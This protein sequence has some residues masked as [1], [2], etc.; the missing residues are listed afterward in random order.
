M[1]RFLFTLLFALLFS[2]P[3]IAADITRATLVADS[4]AITP[5]EPLRLGVLL[6]SQEGWHTYWEN[7]G[8]AGLPTSFTWTLPEGFSAGNIDWPPPLR[9]QESTLVVYGYDNRVFLPVTIRPP[10]AL[11]GMQTL[12][13]KAEWLVC[14]DIC[15]PESAELELTLPTGEKSPSEAAS[16]FEEHDKIRPIPLQAGAISRQTTLAIQLPLAATGMADIASAYFF[17]R[18][19]SI[20]YTAPQ[21]FTV[22]KD[23]LILIAEKAEGFSADRLSGLLSVTS[24]SG[25]RKTFDIQAGL[26]V[27]KP[28]GEP[29][30]M[31]WLLPALLF[32]VLGGAVLNL[33]P[34]VLPVLSLKA[35]AIAKKSGRERAKTLP[36]GLAYTAGI[37]LSFGLIACVLIVLQQAGESV[38]WGFQMQSPAFVGFLAYLLFL[39][40]LSLSGLF[41]LPVLLGNVDNIDENSVKGSFFTGVLA[42]AVATPCTA[43][44]M[45]TAVGVA[46]T[47]P[48]WQSLLI[49]EALGF[50]LALPFLLISL[51][52]ATLRFLPKPGAWMERFKHLLAWP[53]YASVAWLLWVL[54]LQTGLVGL[55]TVIVGMMFITLSISISK[56]KGHR[57]II[58][59]A[60]AIVILT[61]GLLGYVSSPGDTALLREGSVPY[62]KTRL[63]ELRAEGKP[64]FIDATAAWCLTCQLNARVAI[65]TDATQALFKTRGITLMVADW[66]RRNQEITELLNSFGFQGVPLYVYYPANNGKPVV[67][68]QLLTESIIEENL[69]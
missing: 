46:L 42:T 10:A 24:G 58:L 67:L 63:D 9:L 47:L 37:M 56:R 18:E 64:V 49:F 11:E 3:G 36:Q 60:A 28:T 50:G 52:P 45:A 43:P 1:P 40:G 38:G 23:S 19:I 8:D 62:S 31:L 7:P 66:T 25:E 65:H 6:E 34:C 29:Q 51:F 68:P 12:R 17:P 22:E 13:V 35:L 33:M 30:E 59:T 27:E 57:N 44:F 14:K 16:L 41:H 48:A 2:A 20:S 5:G 39:V 61:T 4:A 32:A 15:I 69:R 54:T 55:L 21:T 53:M 26:T